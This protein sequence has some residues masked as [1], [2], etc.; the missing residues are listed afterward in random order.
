LPSFYKALRKKHAGRALTIG[1]EIPTSVAK[2][3]RISGEKTGKIRMGA[4][5]RSCMLRNSMNLFGNRLMVLGIDHAEQTI[6]QAERL[7]ILLERK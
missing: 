6:R 2:F 3:F 5:S 4:K 1:S 7:K